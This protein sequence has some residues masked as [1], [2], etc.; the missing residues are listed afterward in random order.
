M[1]ES[2]NTNY[3]DELIQIAAVAVAAIQDHDHG[4]TAL[5]GMPIIFNEIERERERQLKKWGE[6][7]RH[8]F[9]WM[10]ILGEEVGEACEAALKWEFGQ[11]EQG[12]QPL[13]TRLGQ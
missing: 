2:Y 8:H 4:S 10:T 5:R 9:L 11:D 6:Q 3:R 13:N 7:H 12:E 1:T